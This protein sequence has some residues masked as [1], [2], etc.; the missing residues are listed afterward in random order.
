MKLPKNKIFLAGLVLFLA[1]S[2]QNPFAVA[3]PPV[4]QTNEQA[5]TQQPFSDA[6]IGADGQV[7]GDLVE[8]KGENGKT[9]L[10]LLKVNYPGKVETKSTS[11]G[12]FVSAINGI[13]PDDNHF[14]SFYVNGQLSNEGAGTYKTKDTDT[15]TWKL[16]AIKN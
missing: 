2:C 15:I 13:T 12:E 11:F 10:E 6:V 1:A 8:Y 3:E 4:T 9:A 7:Y 14:W 16:E 5:S